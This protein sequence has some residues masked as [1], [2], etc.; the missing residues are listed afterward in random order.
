LNKII[1]SAALVSFVL[2][3]CYPKPDSRAALPELIITPSTGPNFD[4]SHLF[5]H[6]RNPCDNI[7]LKPDPRTEYQGK[8]IEPDSS[9]NYPPSPINPGDA[10][11]A[12]VAIKSFDVSESELSHHS[13]RTIFES[14]LH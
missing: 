11:C 7:A 1:I 14:G 5:D 2:L 3:G 4:F 12:A 8:V 10:W 9:N 13:N 6:N